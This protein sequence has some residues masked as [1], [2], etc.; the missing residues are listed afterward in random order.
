MSMF[1]PAYFLSLF[2]VEQSAP[3]QQPTRKESKQIWMFRGS[4]VHAYTRSEA[5]AKF[6]KFFD[7]P[8][9]PVGEE[10]R[11]GVVS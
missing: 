1:S 5:R 2:D 6:K 4:V 8:R 7:L 10:V 9:I 11:K 3:R